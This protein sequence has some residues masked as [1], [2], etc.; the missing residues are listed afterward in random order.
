MWI[1]ATG[2]VGREIEE[3]VVKKLNALC[4]APMP[5]VGFPVVPGLWVGIVVLVVVPPR[6]RN[7]RGVVHP[8]SR[9]AEP[10]IYVVTAGLVNTHTTDPADLALAVGVVHGPAPALR[11]GRVPL[12]IAFGFPQ[13]QLLQPLERPVLDLLCARNQVIAALRSPL[14][15][16]IR[17]EEG[18]DRHPLAVRHVGVGHG[19]CSEND[20]R[21]GLG[22][23]EMRVCKLG[24]VGLHLQGAAPGPQEDD[25]HE[26]VA[27]ELR[28]PLGDHRLVQRRRHVLSVTRLVDDSGAPV[29]QVELQ[30]AKVGLQ[31]VAESREGAVHPP[32]RLAASGRPVLL[33]SLYVGDARRTL[34]PQ[35]ALEDSSVYLIVVQVLGVLH[36][37][38]QQAMLEAW[39]E[40]AETLHRQVLGHEVAD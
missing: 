7:L 26:P 34:G 38:R 31:E 33:G 8:G 24:A 18:A 16:H 21:A 17:H 15:Q 5:A 13:L 35:Q 32:H 37:L 3:L 12:G 6:D 14:L 30:R 23:N 22:L 20:R 28:L 2:F 36:R 25:G 19:V 10:N 1:Q 4:K 11:E 29:R 9:A 39:V 27:N 40:H